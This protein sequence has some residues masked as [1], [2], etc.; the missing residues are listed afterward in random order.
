MDLLLMERPVDWTRDDTE[1]DR[2]IARLREDQR[3]QVQM[4]EDASAVVASCQR[5][6]QE[7][8]DE[9]SQLIRERDSWACHTPPQLG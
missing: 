8:A 6:M 4:S 9:I 5:R 3:A 2:C 7:D 1:I